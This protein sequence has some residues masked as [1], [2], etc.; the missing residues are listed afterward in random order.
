MIATSRQPD[1]WGPQ[2]WFVM[3]TV[4]FYYPQSPTVEDMRSAQHFFESLRK[5]LPCRSCRNHY[6]QLLNSHPIDEIVQD[7]M[8]MLRWVHFVHNQVNARLGKSL[9][10]WDDHVASFQYMNRPSIFNTRQRW[11]V[12]FLLASSVAVFIFYHNAKSHRVV[13]AI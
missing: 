8:A 11:N 4:A 10:S 6:K 7:R 12:F 1:D 3:H 9:L 13:K 5:L 2:F